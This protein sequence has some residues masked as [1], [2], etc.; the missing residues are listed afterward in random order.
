[1]FDPKYRNAIDHTRYCDNLY[2]TDA[3]KVIEVMQNVKVPFIA[4]KVMAAG[5]IKPQD[6]FNYSF[7]NGADFVCAGM[8]D[9]Q[10]EQ[11]AQLVTK[12]VAEAK[13][14]KRPWCA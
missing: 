6:A 11:D 3:D 8:F 10:V 12:A 13:N 7:Q 14:R 2:C 1:M 4:F 9:W 5:A